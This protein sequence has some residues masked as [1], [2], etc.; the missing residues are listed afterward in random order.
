[1][2]RIDRRK[3]LKTAAAGA[4]AA[5]LLPLL[6]RKSAMASPFGEFPSVAAPKA[7]PVERRA[8]RVLEVFLYGGLSPWET[9]YYVDEYGRSD[10]PN[11][12]F[13]N[14]QFHAF[15]SGGGADGMTPQ[16]A[17]TRCGVG[18][19]PMGTPFATDALGANVQLGP[20]ASVLAAR[21]DMTSRMRIL[22]TSHNLEPHE[23]AIPL[24]LTGKAVGSPT[25]AGL[26]THI[27]RFFTETPDP[28]R[29][30]PYSY[31]FSTGGLSGDNVSAAFATG[32]HPGRARPLR[33]KIDEA[34]RLTGLLQRPV[35]GSAEERKQY[36]AL[37]AAYA[38]SYQQRLVFPGRTE[39]ARSAKL[40]DLTQASVNVA[41]AD[42][43]ASVMAPEFFEPKDS[44]VCDDGNI[45]IPLMSFKLAAHLLTH[46]TQPAPYVCVVDTGLIEATGGGGYDTHTDNSRDQARN[47]RNCFQQ[48][49][50]IINAPG[51]N[52]PN[53]LD[54]D[55]TLIIFNTEFGR[56][57]KAQDP[58]GG[59]R[60]HHP[61]GY[62]TAVLGGP[63]RDK[64]VVGAIGP[65]GV[66]S[67]FV[68]PSEAR[69]A[70]LLS[71]GIWP[72]SPEAFGVSDVDGAHDEIE[73]VEM[74]TERVLGVQL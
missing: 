5:V 28:N 59:G 63:V 49:T 54:L 56:T 40:A 36:D 27:Q 8:K 62:A 14:S 7:L 57:P 71:L 74:V 51:E 12:K 65:D 37:V 45:N 53:K 31:V 39:A 67:T 50:A 20:F 47:L 61:Y 33:I 3:F 29:K 72:F 24:A 26:G 42:A 9:L 4:G 52:D 6:S 18:T 15:G 48:L 55:D 17:M 35:V 58:S 41:N 68:K 73:A 10:D 23:A 25:M 64:A 16:E 22:A 70:A 13:R 38:H 46:P 19:G 43:V 44:T 11:P 1:M 60:N 21:T 30:A 34:S 69:F 66:A 32:M 2:S